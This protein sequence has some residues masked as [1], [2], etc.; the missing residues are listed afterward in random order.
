MRRSRRLDLL[1]TVGTFWFG[2]L[3]AQIFASGTTSAVKN[4][5]VTDSSFAGWRWADK[6]PVDVA[7]NIGVQMVRASP[8]RDSRRP[9]YAP[10]RACMGVLRPVRTLVAHG[11][12][13]VCQGR[14]DAALQGGHGRDQVRDRRRRAL[15]HVPV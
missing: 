8:R 1:A 11:A 5:D 9:H 2:V 10:C 3:A 13:S 15:I 12:P 14:H 6:L 7:A 4:Y